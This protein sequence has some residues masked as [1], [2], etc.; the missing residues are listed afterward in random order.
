MFCGQ[1][2]EIKKWVRTRKCLK[3]NTQHLQT[4]RDVPAGWD[5]ALAF[6][7]RGMPAL[8][9][10]ANAKAAE[11]AALQTLRDVPTRWTWR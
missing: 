8:S 4:L 7:M 3:R 6:G 5:L 1:V 2:S 9:D 10:R 11:Y